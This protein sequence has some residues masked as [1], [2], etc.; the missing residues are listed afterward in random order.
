MNSFL[1]HHRC[2]FCL[3]TWTLYHCGKFC[4]DFTLVSIVGLSKLVAY[5]VYMFEDIVLTAPHAKQK[6]D[7]SC[8]SVNSSLAA[9]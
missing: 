9:A 8:S 1:H 3:C 6:E 5:T 2:N 4:A 7:L